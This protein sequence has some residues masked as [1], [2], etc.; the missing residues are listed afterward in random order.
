MES[1]LNGEDVLFSWTLLISGDIGEDDL[2]N[3]LLTCV[4]KFMCWRMNGILQ[5]TKQEVIIKQKSSKG[6]KEQD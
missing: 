5:T 1:I 2:T 3:E 6:I 4:V